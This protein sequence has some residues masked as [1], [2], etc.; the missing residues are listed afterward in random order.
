MVW[1]YTAEFIE[2]AL[3]YAQ[4]DFTLEDIYG[5]I[6]DKKMQLWVTGRENTHEVDGCAVTEIVDTPRLKYCRVVLLGGVEMTR[7]LHVEEAVANWAASLGC[8]RIEAVCRPGFAKILPKFGYEQTHVVMCKELV[9][10]Q[11][12]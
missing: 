5:F 10:R 7:W 1:P 12:H 3:E 4:G 11:L 9:E 8:K 6:S 2:D